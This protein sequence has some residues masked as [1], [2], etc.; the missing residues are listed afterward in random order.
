MIN[1]KK[2]L[3]IRN[4][5]T[6][7]F[8][9]LLAIKGDKGDKGDMPPLSNE[10]GDS[11]TV[12]ASQKL[13]FDEVGKLRGQ[14]TSNTTDIDALREQLT[15]HMSGSLKTV[16]GSYVG[17]GKSVSKTLTFDGLN[18]VYLLV[19]MRGSLNFIYIK[20][21]NSVQAHYVY[22]VPDVSVTLYQL[23]ITAD[24]GNITATGSASKGQ[25]Y[26]V[27]NDSDTTYYYFALGI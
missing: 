14:V 20:G 12:A 27:L 3:K 15:N 7:E 17:D 1:I 16:C 4:P 6:G 10:L 24:G 13:V 26:S 23:S 2:I 5:D 19:I 22:T 18:D 9:P 21:V 25:S 8:E 11:E